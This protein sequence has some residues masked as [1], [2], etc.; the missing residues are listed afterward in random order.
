MPYRSLLLAALVVAS[1]PA[2]AGESMQ[3][4]TEGVQIPRARGA[5]KVPV[6]RFHAGRPDIATARGDWP[7]LLGR[8]GGGADISGEIDLR[9]ATLVAPVGGALKVGDVVVGSVGEDGTLPPAELTHGIHQG[10]RNALKLLYADTEAVSS[11]GCRLGAVPGRSATGNLALILDERLPVETVHTLTRSAREA[12]FRT[13]Y[14]AVEDSMAD[15][16]RIP[17][18]RSRWSPH[19]LSLDVGAGGYAVKVGRAEEQAVPCDATPCTPANRPVS[20]LAALVSEGQSAADSD[21]LVL[22][23]SGRIHLA[24]LVQAWT[25]AVGFEGDARR[26]DDAVIDLSCE[27]CEGPA[28]RPPPA[29]Q[30]VEEVGSTLTAIRWHL[31]YDG[32]R[33]D[34]QVEKA[35]L[36]RI[37]E[38]TPPEPTVEAAFERQSGQLRFCYARH[39]REHPELAGTVYLSF[40]IGLEGRVVTSKVAASTLD[41]EETEQCVLRLLRRMQFTAPAS[42]EPLPVIRAVE[43]SPAPM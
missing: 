7:E 34:V 23:V 4:S 42:G 19:V 17:P 2:M 24:D 26:F 32:D 28:T 3:I 6:R 20:R 8:C 9:R 31:P 12:G 13:F 29:R 16:G 41:H 33:L 18:G 1:T 37:P 10:V 43:F 36:R 30:V 39:L 40:V 38:T 27:D 5:W 21:M 11:L 22:D 35:S 25:T 15:P 14:L